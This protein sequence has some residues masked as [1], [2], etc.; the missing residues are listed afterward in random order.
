MVEGGRIVRSNVVASQFH[1]HAHY[2]GVVPEV[3]SR[4][5]LEV[6][7]QVIDA[8]LAEAGVRAG[9]SR[10]RRRDRRARVSRARCSSASTVAKAL[11]Y[12]HEL[13]LLGVNHLEGHL[14]ANWLEVEGRE[15]RPPELPRSASSSP[16]AT[17]TSC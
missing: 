10:R 5:H 12:A 4:H 13:P 3:A 1:L 15:Y 14:Y 7:L 2:G 9:R 17:P 8:A 16:A 11:A 6:I